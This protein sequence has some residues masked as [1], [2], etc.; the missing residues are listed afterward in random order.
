[1]KYI[2][3]AEH[4]SGTAAEQL[5]LRHLL[6]AART[7]PVPAH[8]P[9]ITLVPLPKLLDSGL[10]DARLLA[11]GLELTHA[12]YSHLG[13]LALLPLDRINAGYQSAAPTGTA[14][15]HGGFHHPGQGY[16]H[17]QMDAAITLAGDLSRP[18]PSAPAEITLDLIRT[19][20]H[21]CLHY[22]TYRKYQLTQ[23]GD[24]A[25]TQYGTNPRRL[26]GRT[27]S[28]PDS[29]QA[30]TTRNLGILMEAATDVEATSIARSVASRHGLMVTRPETGMASFAFAD[31]TG[32]VT[33][34]LATTARTH[35]IHMSGPQVTSIAQS[36]VATARFSASRPITHGN[37]TYSSSKPCLT[38]TWLIS[39][40]GLLPNT[41]TERSLS[42]SSQQRTTNLVGLW[43]AGTREEGRGRCA[44][45]RRGC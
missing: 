2:L 40:T 37:C 29:S 38:A 33:P 24:I 42:A 34:A 10:I 41:A 7:N 8:L 9:F 12:R 21:D 32:V 39:M 1:M 17:L 6:L 26:D 31:T 11:D 16:R 5:R 35:R 25:R 19:Y 43:A 44:G 28:A 20:A 13:A 27:Y 3:P 14:H 18:Q 36:R 45:E 4:F 23:S 15:S 22:A 30:L